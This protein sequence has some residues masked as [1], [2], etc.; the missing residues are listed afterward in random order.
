MQKAGIRCAG[1]SGGDTPQPQPPPVSLL[2]TMANKEV[3]W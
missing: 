3:G 1:G 2:Y